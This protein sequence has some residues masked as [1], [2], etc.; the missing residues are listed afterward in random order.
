MAL[1]IVVTGSIDDAC[2]IYYS[3]NQVIYQAR[4]NTILTTGSID[5]ACAIYYNANQV[6]YQTKFNTIL[7]GTFY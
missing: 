1:H 5:D 3:A 7:T 2:A 6:I 4:F